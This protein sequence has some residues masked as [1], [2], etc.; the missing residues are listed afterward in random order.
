[1]IGYVHNVELRRMLFDSGSSLNISP[2]STLQAVGIPLDRIIE[3]LIEVSVF[4]DS[5]SFSIGYTQHDYRVYVSSNSVHAIDAR[6]SYHLLLG[7]P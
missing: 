3:Q 4:G 1:M 6:A 2:L 5:V 7:R